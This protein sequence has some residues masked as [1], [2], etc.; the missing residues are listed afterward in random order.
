MLFPRYIS[1]SLKSNKPPVQA[2]MILFSA[3][4]R[5]S[6]DEKRKTAKES[7]IN[8]YRLS[9]R[10]CFIWSGRRGKGV[11]GRARRRLLEEVVEKQN[12]IWLV[13]RKW[14]GH[15]SKW[16]KLITGGTVYYYYYKSEMS[17]WRSNDTFGLWLSLTAP[18][19]NS[20]RGRTEISKITTTSGRRNLHSPT[21][22]PLLIFDCRLPPWYKFLSL[23]SLPQ[24]LKLKIVA[25]IFVKKILS[26]R[27]PKLGCA[28]ILPARG[29][30]E[31]HYWRLS[32]S[33]D[34]RKL[35]ANS[36]M[37]HYSSFTNSLATWLNQTWTLSHGLNVM[38][39]L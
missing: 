16:V 33:S 26:T 29:T 18:I 4:S 39:T 31:Q 11:E 13:A 24:P 9:H 3:C 22:T 17:E 37:T 14:V 12:T 6:V 35:S 15:Q 25:K 1:F 36:N 30:P 8:C 32:E 34:Y 20:F 19:R 7:H 23:P 38:N 27:S 5:L 10:P 2:A 28:A 21:P